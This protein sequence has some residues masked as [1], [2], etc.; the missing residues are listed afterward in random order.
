MFKTPIFS[1][2]QLKTPAIAIIASTLA[3]STPASA[4]TLRITMTNLAPPQGQ[5]IAPVWFGFHDGSFDL[6][7]EGTPA[8]TAIEVMAEDGIIGNP[9]GRVPPDFLAAFIAAGADPVALAIAASNSISSDF[10]VSPAGMSGGYQDLLLFDR[11]VDPYFGVQLSGEK[12]TTVVTLDDNTPSNRFF[13]Y[14][15]MLFPTN[16]G[17]IGND[18]PLEVFDAAGNFLGA[19]FII[20]GNEVW[21][22][23]TEVNDEDLIN[24][25]FDLNNLF[26]GEDEGGV[27]RR[28]PGLLPAGSGGI[29]DLEFNGFRFSNADLSAP[30]Y[31]I[32]RIQ[33]EQV[34]VPEYTSLLSFLSLGILGVGAAVFGK[35]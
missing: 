5:G 13:S 33:I 6:F 2:P 4:I 23:G 19:D 12:T 9:Q 34:I 16:D 20:S 14:A 22:A 3:I 35:R 28:H 31:Q 1:F 17:F 27:V 32:A 26:V 10:A 30:G 29:L 25:P 21:D 7:D 15:G 8:S 18:D 11:R 24:P